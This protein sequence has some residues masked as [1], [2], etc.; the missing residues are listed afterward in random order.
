MSVLGIRNQIH[1]L[2][3]LYAPTYDFDHAL[4][5]RIMAKA[6]LAEA[7]LRDWEQKYPA[8]GQIPR[9]V[10]LLDQLYSKIQLGDAQTKAK[11]CTQWLFTRYGNSWY[12]KNMRVV[13]KETVVPSP[14]PSPSGLTAT[15][16]ADTPDS[17]SASAPAAP[18]VV[19]AASS[20]PAPKN[21]VLPVPKKT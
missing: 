19:P 5:K 11:A 3:I 10:Y 7:S 2:G 1:D 21:G 12:A 14:S 4:A 6:V 18:T 15:P 9:Y 13:T 16:A 8:D 17:F 20:A